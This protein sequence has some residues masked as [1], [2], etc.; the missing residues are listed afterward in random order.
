M[1]STAIFLSQQS[2]QYFSSPRGSE[3]SFAL[4][5]AQRICATDF[6]DIPG[7]C[8]N[9]PTPHRPA[10]NLAAGVGRWAMGVGRWELGIGNWELGVGNWELGVQ[11]PTPAPLRSAGAYMVSTYS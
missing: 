2:R 7:D 9:P 4:Q 6:R 5:S 3:T 11:R 8:I 10:A 1:S